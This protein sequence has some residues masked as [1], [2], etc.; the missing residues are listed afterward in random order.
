VLKIFTKL[1]DAYPYREVCPICGHSMSESLF[2]WD[3]QNDNSYSLPLSDSKIRNIKVDLYN[4]DRLVFNI[5][6]NTIIEF[7][8]TQPMNNTFVYGFKQIP[9]AFI[10]GVTQPQYTLYNGIMLCD[11][12]IDCMYCYRYSYTLT[13]KININERRI[14]EAILNSELITLEYDK[15]NVYEIRNVYTIDKTEYTP[16][17]N[18]KKNT[19]FKT[20]SLPLISNDVADPYDMLNRIKKLLVFS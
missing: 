15:N 12:S 1:S 20:I 19:G 14:D 17:N 13:L 4:G 5:D 10:P 6:S 9:F 16:I 7:S 2:C 8:I 11:H 18:T 3:I